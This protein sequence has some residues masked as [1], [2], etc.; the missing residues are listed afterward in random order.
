MIDLRLCDA[1][2]P[3]CGLPSLADG[4]VASVITDAPFDARTHRAA[5]ELGDWRRGRRRVAGALPFSPLDRETLAAVARQLARVARR[6]ILVFAP[7]RMI[8]TWAAA[9]EM[10][11]AR[12]VRIGLA[13]RDNPRPQMTGDRPAPSC[14]FVVIAHAGAGRLRWNGHGRAGA[15]RS[16]AARFDPGGQIHTAQKSLSLL[17]ALVEDFSDA[18]ELVCDP[19]AGVG[20]CA[21]AC[22]QLGREFIGYEIDPAYHA[23]ALARIERAQVQLRLRAASHAGHQLTLEREKP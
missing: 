13:L 11:G 17:R 14:D 1:L 20:T 9:L 7:E 16:S 23:P 2:D 19:F 12:F 22:K 15:W 3:E 6:W 5:V 18:G 10:A 8:E 4:S 21:V